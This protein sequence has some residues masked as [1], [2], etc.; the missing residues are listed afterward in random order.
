MKISFKTVLIILAGISIAFSLCLFA[1]A[2][3]VTIGEEVEEVSET[4]HPYQPAP[5]LGPA[6]S[7]EQAFHWPGASY[8][9]IHFDGFDLGAGDYVEVAGPSG[10]RVYS[11]EGNGKVVR[12]GQA[13][14]STFWSGVIWGDTASVRLYTAGPTGG[15]GFR[16]DRWARGFEKE[17]FEMIMEEEFPGPETICGADDKRWAKCYEGTTMYEKART[18]ARLLVG[19]TLA[20]TGWLVGYEGHIMTNNHIIEDQTQADNTEYEFMAEGATCTT[21]CASWFACPGTVVAASGTL[22][23]TNVNLDY[24][25]VLLPV[26]VSG[27]YG[28]MQLRQSLP[29]VGERI[30][31]PQHPQAYGKQMAVVSTDSHDPTGY[32]SV[33]STGENPCIGGSHQ[34]IGYYGDTEP[35]SSGSPVIA[36]DDHL[37]VAL[38]HCGGCP[39]QGVPISII[40]SELVSSGNLPA[41]AIS[42]VPTPTP[43]PS[44]KLY[45]S[46]FKDGSP[47]KGLFLFRKPDPGDWTYWD[48]HARN[49]SILLEDTAAIPGGEVVAATDVD[50]DGDGKSEIAVLKRET[51]WDMNLYLYEGLRPPTQFNKFPIAY[52]FW[53]IPQGNNILFMANAGDVN[54]DGREDIAVMRKE[55]GI[56]YNLYIYNSPVR[57][58]FTHDDAWSRN[59]VPI[60]YDKWFIPQGNDTVALAGVD[61]DGDFSNDGLAAVRDQSGDY[62]LYIWKTPAAGDWFYSQ[63]EARQNGYGGPGT[64]QARDFWLIPAG[65]DIVAIAPVQYRNAPEAKIAVIKNQGGDQNLYIYNLPKCP[66]RTYYDAV[67]RNPTPL[68]RDFWIIPAGNRIVDTL[69]T[70]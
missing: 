22:V 68:A 53:I 65:N 38:H 66:D 36:Y 34:E 39:N 57:G 46:A 25:L 23:Q 27:T 56:D 30:Y 1:E 16:I 47:N 64:P 29:T 32:C 21:D 41:G 5:G 55:A 18:V 43:T 42:S 15:W 52:D 67:V 6:L 44:V 48:A 59:I 70:N 24:S 2:G 63:A 49:P 13:V 10:N 11:Y 12:G 7:W 19:G 50:I 37:V 58:D 4:D 54:G 14:L 17:E 9:R 33:Y 28:Y 31:I 3:G 61:L 20:G 60:A 26:N 69:G 45:L 40:I 62:N 51:G 35:G 8:I